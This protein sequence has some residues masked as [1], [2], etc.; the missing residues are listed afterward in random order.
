VWFRGC[1]L[2]CSGCIAAENIAAGRGARARSR[3]AVVFSRADLLGAA[4]GYDLTEWATRTGSAGL[5]WAAR[6]DFKEVVLFGTTAAL[7]DTGTDPTVS[8]LLP[9]CSR[10]SR[11]RRSWPWLGRRRRD[12]PAGS[13]GTAPATS[14]GATVRHGVHAADRSVRGAL[15]LGPWL[16]LLG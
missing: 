8:D 3:L 7:C 5:L 15:V 9:G 11:Y 10:P 12:R 16:G 6:M 13:A 2:R 1:P 4:S 14:G